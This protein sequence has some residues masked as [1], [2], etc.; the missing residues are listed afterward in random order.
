SLGNVNNW[1]PVERNDRLYTY[2]ANINWI[3]GAHSVRGGFDFL[4]HQLNHWQP[5]IGAW[6]PRGGFTFGNGV[7][8]LNGGAA[9]NNYNAYA[10]FLLGLPSQFGK[11]YQ[12][13]DP[14][15]T[16]EFQQ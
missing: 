8:A 9:A 2:V 1:S 10:A 13:Y 15:K 12:F 5:E 3:R 14:M 11:S 7:T 4:Q 6:S 16:R